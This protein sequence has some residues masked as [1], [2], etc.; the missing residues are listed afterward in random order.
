MMS[1]SIIIRPASKEDLPAIIELL[2]D[3]HLGQS[4]ESN[5]PESLLKYEQA[6]ERIN[7]DKSQEL[8]VAESLGEVV[9]TFQLTLIPYLNY[10]GSLRVL[11]ESVH[12]R[13]DQR[14]HGTGTQM[15][16]WAVDRAKSKGAKIIQL[17]SDKRRPDAL[18]FYRRL[19]F[20]ETHEGFKMHLF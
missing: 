8:M 12:V 18:K 15:M 6:F 16:E 10:E 9:G 19:G 2:T 4:R 13:A 5:S 3:D 7:A 20:K 11:I 17:T 14:G 1:K